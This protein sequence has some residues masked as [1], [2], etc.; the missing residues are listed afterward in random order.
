[1][2]V[3]AIIYGG[4][5][6]VRSPYEL[7]ATARSI[8]G[9]LWQASQKC[10]TYPA[11]PVAA[12]KIYEA[13]GM[14]LQVDDGFAALIDKARELDAARAHREGIDL[15]DLPSP[16]EAP[17]A[18]AHQRQAYHFALASPATML[19]MDMGTGKTRVAVALWEGW[20]AKR[21]LVIST[22]NGAAF[23]W[24]H[25]I[26]Q[27]SVRDWK[28]AW[29]GGMNQRTGEPLASF[30]V[31]NRVEQAVQAFDEA[32]DG[33]AVVVIHYAAMTFQPFAAW[34]LSQKWDV[35]VLDESHNV[36]A[37]GGVWSQ[38][39]KKLSGRAE[40]R[41]CLTGTPMPHSKLDAY[42]QYRF[43]DQGVFGSSFARFRMRFAVMG[44]FEGREVTGWQ[45]EEAFD[46][47][48]SSLA[49][50]CRADD[51]LDL[52]AGHHVVRRFKL[53][54][55]AAKAYNEMERNYI[56]ELDDG[57]SAEASNVL[58]RL[59]RLAQITSGHLPVERKCPRCDG[60]GCTVCG[61]GFYHETVPVGTDK[62]DLLA[63]VLDGL[64][65]PVAVFARFVHDL[66]AIERVA[67]A[68][69]RTYGEI[70]GR[71]SDLAEGATF[72]PNTSILGVQIQAGS[73]AIDL[74]RARYAIYYSVGFD[75][76]KYRQSLRRTRRPGQERPVTYFHLLAQ[77]TVDEA[78]L[79]T[80]ESNE[81]VV[82]GVLERVRDKHHGAGQPHDT[83]HPGTL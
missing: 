27:W 53:G 42:A 22:P 60:K 76:G 68:L 64:N 32:G 44:G 62:A 77:G 39:T 30:S 10:W 19:A 65:E 16:D 40:R 81:N 56:A 72:P 36:K 6:Y 2:S 75:N 21:V 45:N 54:A 67:V 51:V 47:D 59:L 31:A 18:W 3:G 5:I 74:T 66:D 38:F 57:E 26:P 63:E 82:Q 17:P 37:P 43:L 52:P 34:A 79:A 33:P 7:R 48:F 80:L 14:D 71:R 41:L 23:V 58:A 69:G 12:M 11:T 15:S 20:E 49:Y 50:V 25:Q 55:K 9:G 70:S 83:A 24:P 8:P 1:M 4:R 29:H 73:E 78:E 35:V 13:F 61:D 28:I 46:R